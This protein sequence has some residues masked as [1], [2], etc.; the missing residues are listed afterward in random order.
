MIANLL[1][2]MAV[3]WVILASVVLFLIGYRWW[4]AKSEDDT[5]HLGESEVGVVS[6]QVVTGKKLEYIDHWGKILTAVAL[7]WGLVVAGIAMY[8]SWAAQP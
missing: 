1:P 5:L 4:I 2:W 3:L 6:R 7:V 8:Q